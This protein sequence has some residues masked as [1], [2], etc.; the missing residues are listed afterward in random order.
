[1]HRTT[2][3]LQIVLLFVLGLLWTGTDQLEADETTARN[4]DEVAISPASHDANGFFVHTVRSPYQGGPSEIRVLLPDGLEKDQRVSVV[5]LL[6]VEAGNGKVYGNGLAEARRLGLHIRHQLAFVAP[7]FSHLPWYADHPT[8][9]LIR[10][11]SYFRDVVIPFVERTYPVRAEPTGRLLVGFSKSGWGALSLLARHP[12]LFHK[13]AVWDAPLMM[14]AP[15]RF[16]SGPIFGSEKNFEQYHLE[17]LLARKGSDVKA[18]PRIALMGYWGFRDDHR[19]AHELLQS[20]DIPHLYRDGPRRDHRWEGG[21]LPEAV[22]FVADATDDEFPPEL[23]KFRPYADNPI[24]VAGGEGHWDVRIRERGWI[25]PDGER[26]HLWFTGYDGTRPGQK[27]LGYATS[28]D[29][30][31]WTRHRNNPIYRDHWVEDVMVV[32]RG[33]T[34]YM[35]AEGRGDQPY[36]FTSTDAVQWNRERPLDIRHVDGSPIEPGPSGTPTAWFEE[37]TWYLFYE[38]R[39][40]GI[41]LATSRDLH[42][43]THIQDEPVLLPGPGRYDRQLVAMNQ[44]VKHNGRY[45]A[46]YHGSAAEQSPALWTTNVAV[47]SDLIHWKKYA[48][49]PLFPVRQNKSSG[50]LVHDKKQFRL[51]TMHGKVDLHLPQN[52]EKHTTAP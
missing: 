14:A 3:R 52:S 39:D 22:A 25:L 28:S 49:N 30:I 16:G 41:W 38:R 17:R 20:L 47:S 11:E 21:W 12:S 19:R 7:T 10:Q 31:A 46:Y 29:G 6:P 35:F 4:G 26:Y 36:L 43:W 40:L 45:Y 15:G 24:F 8:D 32:K 33:E 13:V 18:F 9:P 48:A 2:N 50:I 34:F 27:M 5:Y 1:M 51:Y 37:G 23:V 42:T 44:I